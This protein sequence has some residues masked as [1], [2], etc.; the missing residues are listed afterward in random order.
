[1]A[2][3]DPRD[4][5]GLDE[6]AKPFLESDRYAAWE[7]PFQVR[8]LALFQSCSLNELSWLLYFGFKGEE[9][10]LNL[11]CT[12]PGEPVAQEYDHMFPGNVIS[13]LEIVLPQGELRDTQTV[14]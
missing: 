13:L 14:F 11:I 7:S 3:G 12:R 10:Q 1:M 2:A 5:P 8:A 6:R 4:L 9:G